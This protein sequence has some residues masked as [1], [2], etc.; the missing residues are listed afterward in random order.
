MVTMTFLYS[1]LYIYTHI[2]CFKLPTSLLQ[3]DFKDPTY[4]LSSP[5]CFW[6]ILH[7]SAC[8]CLK[9][10]LC[11]HM[12]ILLLSLTSLLA[13]CGWFP[14]FM[15]CLLLPAHSPSILFLFLVGAFCFFFQRISSNF[16]CKARFVVVNS[17][18][19]WKL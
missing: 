3:V 15:V 14:T 8:V 4:I 6:Y 10:L 5:Y 19:F 11:L 16:C 2:C 7:L 12:I 9:C 18:S 1:S 17:F 13:L